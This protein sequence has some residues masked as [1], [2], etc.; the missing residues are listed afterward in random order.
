MYYFD[1]HG[2]FE[3]TNISSQ[4]I[5]IDYNRRS[6]NGTLKLSRQIHS[7]GVLNFQTNIS[8]F[9]ISKGP[10]STRYAYTYASASINKDLF[11]KKATLSLTA[12]DIFN[13]NQTKRDRFDTN[14]YSK[15]VIKNK[16][17]EII[18]S[19]TYRFNQSKKNRKIDF[20]K[21]DKKPNF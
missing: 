16:Y 2:V 4:S 6:F 14:Y 1:Q 5:K 20:D 7:T 12:N 18:L 19:F 17:Q 21:K 10:V 3:T 9:L 13:S 8:H 11:D 15:S